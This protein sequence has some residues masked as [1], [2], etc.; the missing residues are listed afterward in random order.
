MTEITKTVVL[1]TF[2][3]HYGNGRP[4]PTDKRR[5][6]EAYNAT[7]DDLA[8]FKEGRSE[9]ENQDFERVCAF[10]V[11]ILRE[12]FGIEM[13]SG[14][15]LSSQEGAGIKE[16][17]KVAQEFIKGDTNRIPLLPADEAAA[18]DWH[19]TVRAWAFDLAPKDRLS[20]KEWLN[21][22]MNGFAGELWRYLKVEELD[23]P[24]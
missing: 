4:D 18:A 24:R 20:D 3:S 21:S 9:K 6:L 12:D 15:K 7:L 2:M 23:H 22:F 10:L 14:R 19:K 13:R 17:G 5:A 8:P 16:G 1:K 11:E